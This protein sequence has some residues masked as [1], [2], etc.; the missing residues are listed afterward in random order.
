MQYTNISDNII[1][2]NLGRK[3]CNVEI[4]FT[5][6]PFGSGKTYC[7]YESQFDHGDVKKLPLQGKT[8]KVEA[9]QLWGDKAC[10]QGTL[11]HDTPD[12]S[13]FYAGLPSDHSIVIEYTAWRWFLK[14]R[15]VIVLDWDNTV[16]SPLGIYPLAVVPKEL[17]FCM[18]A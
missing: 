11:K 9:Y 2:V 10:G 6:G 3:V 7:N 13:E 4:Y 15:R 5:D 16:E 14:R 12:S 17:M 1:E 18:E 8:I